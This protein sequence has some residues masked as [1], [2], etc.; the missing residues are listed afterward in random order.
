MIWSCTYSF[1]SIATYISLQDTVSSGKKTLLWLSAFAVFL[2]VLLPPTFHYLYFHDDLL[3]FPQLRMIATNV[4]SIWDPNYGFRVQP[5][6]LLFLNMEYFLFGTFVPAYFFVLFCM[7]F[8][9]AY[10]IMRLCSAFGG[11]ERIGIISGLLFLFCSSFFQIFLAVH[12]VIRV[13]CL[14]FFLLGTLLWLQY[15]RLRRVRDVCLAIF[16]Q[17]VALLTMEDAMI[18]PLLMG[19]LTLAMLSAEDRKKSFWRVPV[20]ISFCIDVL[21]LVPILMPFWT[22][23]YRQGKVSAHVS[24]W[25]A[26]KSLFESLIRPL[27]L[28]EKGLIASN[29]LRVL[30]VCAGIVVFMA[31]L[32]SSKERAENFLKNLC[33]PLFFFGVLWIA[34]AATPFFAYPLPFDHASR[35]LYFP[36]VGLCIVMG[37]LFSAVWRGLDNLKRVNFFL[38]FSLAFLSFVGVNLANIKYHFN[39]YQQYQWEH[40]YEEGYPELVQRCLQTR[41]DLEKRP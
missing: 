12:C 40:R 37:V 20:F 14:F 22:S 9:N 18:F 2:C 24:P 32:L 10:L 33:W 26:V 29:L 7:H 39:E 23:P 36:A 5:V 15:L 28:P 38:I 13:L 8:F 3:L 31:I 1:T 41:F 17:I 30:P 34:C 19:I 35:H 21:L 4:N 25:E 11:E 27:F 6:F 16:F